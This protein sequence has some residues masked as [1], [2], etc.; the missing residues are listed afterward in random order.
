MITNE[1]PFQPYNMRLKLSQQMQLNYSK[2]K[3]HVSDTSVMFEIM[4]AIII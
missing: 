3:Q 1:F 2:I 4:V